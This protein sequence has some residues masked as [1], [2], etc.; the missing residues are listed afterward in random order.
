MSSEQDTLTRDNVF[1][2]LSN[3]RRRYILYYLR[4]HDGPIKLTD[5]ADEVAAWEYDTDVEE[6][7]KQ[8][9]KRVYVSLYQ[10]H[11]PKLAEIGLV[12]YD[13]SVGLIRP[14]RRVRA[15]DAYLPS[16][17]DEE[18]H[19]EFVYLGLVVVGA[20]LFAVGLVGAGGLG[21]VSTVPVGLVILVLFAMT[22]GIHYYYRTR[23]AER[24]PSELDF[25]DEDDVGR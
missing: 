9:R 12:D 16:D 11:V 4:T 23:G 6:L 15:V 5:L 10:T 7:S 8:E 3:P 21:A 24:L 2:L 20:V 18:P 1:D 25:R 22:A 19:W 17:E 14:T 13:A